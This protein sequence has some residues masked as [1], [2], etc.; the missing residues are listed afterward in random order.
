MLDRP[1]RTWNKGKEITASG[2]ARILE[3]FKIAPTTILLKSEGGKQ[4]NGYKVE[5][6]SDAF[7]RYLPPEASLSSP[8][9]GIS[10][11]SAMLES[12]PFP[13]HGELRTRSEPQGKPELGEA[14]EG[15][16]PLPPA[17]RGISWRVLATLDDY[18]FPPLPRPAGFEWLDAAIAALEQGGGVA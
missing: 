9:S 5:Q 7:R 2:V 11:S 12:S 16:A 13:T 18:R 1:W 6:F 10:A 14:G 15:R 8:T 4:P 17:R 3:P